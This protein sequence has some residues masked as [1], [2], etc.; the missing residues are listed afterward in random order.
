[1]LLWLSILLLCSMVYGNDDLRYPV[2][3]EVRA[4]APSYSSWCIFYPE[5]CRLLN[6]IDGSSGLRRRYL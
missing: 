3:R 1:M 6:S 4:I 2:M 5:R